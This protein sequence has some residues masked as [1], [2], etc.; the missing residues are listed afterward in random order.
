MLPSLA[1]SFYKAIYYSERK[2][3]DSAINMEIFCRLCKVYLSA[4]RRLSG[5]KLSAGGIDDFVNPGARDT[6]C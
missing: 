1:G 3:L 4:F 6:V 2:L 5:G